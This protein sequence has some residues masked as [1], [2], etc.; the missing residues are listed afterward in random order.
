[1][2]LRLPTEMLDAMILFTTGDDIHGCFSVDSSHYRFN[3]YRPVEYKFTSNHIPYLAHP[4]TMSP[5]RS[6]SESWV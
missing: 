1:M 4:T 3:W 6:Y 2:I 5:E